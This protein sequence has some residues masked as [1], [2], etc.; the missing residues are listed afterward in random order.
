MCVEGGFF[1]SKSVSVTSRLLARWEYLNFTNVTTKFLNVPTPLLLEVT[2]FKNCLIEHIRYALNYLAKEKCLQ[3]N[4]N[5]F[6]YT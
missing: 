6:S 3:E 5:I 1:F 2:F 4:M